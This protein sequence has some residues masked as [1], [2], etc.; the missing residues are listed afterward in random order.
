M[1]DLTQADVRSYV[2]D[3]FLV[4]R[5]LVSADDVAAIR[6]E[7]ARFA[8]GEYP[9]AN[10]QAVPTG[11][12]SE[13]AAE[14]LLA[15]HF[16][17]WVSDVALQFVHHEGVV[18]VLERITAA[19]L[20]H[21]DGSVKCM[22]S[23]L[24]V[25]PPGMQGQAWHQD[26]RFIPTRDRSLTGVWIAVD[27]ATTENGCLWVI[28]GSHRNG[29]LWPTAAH[30]RPDEFDG[31]DEAHGFDESAEVAVEVSAGSV[32]FFNGYLLHRSRRNRSQT[33]R[34]AL[35][36]HYCNSWSLLHWD[37]RDADAARLVGSDY[38]TV[39]HVSG[40]D[41]YAWKGYTAPPPQVYVRPRG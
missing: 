30:G 36:N 10:P 23:M 18:S 12:S 38:R 7:I 26:E 20:P 34:R 35:V 27:D 15:I 1:T 28:P 9:V 2:D 33:Y 8:R 25:K 39:V 22:Q 19:H 3:G 14:H 6:D 31:A 21:W 40:T 29:Y 37:I 5:D 16:P 24:F 13:E 32:V 17:H 11:L 41:P 4:V